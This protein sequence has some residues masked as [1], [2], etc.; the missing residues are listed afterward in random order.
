M[1]RSIETRLKRLEDAS[2]PGEPPRRS[3]VIGLENG[4][5]R[6]AKE[7]AKA[8]LI[9]SGAAGPDDFFWFLLPLE[10]DSPSA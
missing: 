3:H 2:A 5:D 10:S 4:H 8:E 1:N 7:A 6:E 9:A